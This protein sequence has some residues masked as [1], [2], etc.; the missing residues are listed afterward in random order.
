M[1]PINALVFVGDG[2]LQG[3]EDFGYLSKAMA[4]A[5]VAALG[6][7]LNGQGIE[8]VWAALIVL[9]V[10]RAAGLGWRYYGGQ[11]AGGPWAEIAKD[12][13]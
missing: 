5:S 10:T 9:Q 6:V 2:V 4:V 12:A 3:S 8:N 1:Q 11:A 7:L 13:D